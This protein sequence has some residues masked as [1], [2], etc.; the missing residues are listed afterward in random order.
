MKYNNVSIIIQGPICKT[1]IFAIAKYSELAEVILSFN[2]DE[3]VPNFLKTNK[4]S[5]IK[6]ICYRSKETDR[7]VDKIKTCKMN[8]RHASYHF[9]STKLGIDLSEKKFIIKA[10]SDEFYENM[11]YFIKIVKSN[12]KFVVTNNVFYINPNSHKCHPSDHLIGSSSV[13]M[14]R[15][16]EILLE[17]IESN[18]LSKYSIDGFNVNCFSPEQYIS[19]SLFNAMHELYGLALNKENFGRY[20]RKIRVNKLG[21]YKVANNESRMFFINNYN[22]NPAVHHMGI[23]SVE[24]ELIKF[25]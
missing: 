19:V 10:R 2:N 4:N 12:P 1:T 25:I 13:I 24:E 22:P 15:G 9:Y 20:F 18:I 17:C 11:D 6:V 5:N 7:Y 14:K 8:Q 16:F 21:N 3:D 23:D